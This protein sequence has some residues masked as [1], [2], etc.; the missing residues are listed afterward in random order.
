[1]RYVHFD[2]RRRICVPQ[3]SLSGMATLRLFMIED[4]ILRQTQLS[5]LYSN[6]QVGTCIVQQAN[7]NTVADWPS[8]AHNLP[9]T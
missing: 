9:K 8:E 7:S 2:T 4:P 3:Y 5:W 6:V 1:M